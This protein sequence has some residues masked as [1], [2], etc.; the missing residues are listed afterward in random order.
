MKEGKC[1]HDYNVHC[2]YKN[3]NRIDRFCCDGWI[4]DAGWEI[5]SVYQM[6]T[7]IA[8]I[9]SNVRPLITAFVM[10]AVSKATKERKEKNNEE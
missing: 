2:I 9:D 10:E 1:R 3:Y 5:S 7:W 6:G 8:C 4:V